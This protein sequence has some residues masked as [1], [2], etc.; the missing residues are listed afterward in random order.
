MVA[1]VFSGE[2]EFQNTKMACAERSFMDSQSFH[3]D[4]TIPI[5]DS[6]V[7]LGKKR[8]FACS[9]F[10]GI[11]LLVDEKRVKRSLELLI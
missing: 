5:R 6:K 10:S 9:F 1:L 7:N 8:L 11:T 4:P 3:L 2:S